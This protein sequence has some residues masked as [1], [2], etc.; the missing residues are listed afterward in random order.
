MPH[1]TLRRT[2]GRI[3]LSGPHGTRDLG[4]FFSLAGSRAQGVKAER[5][6]EFQRTVV[7]PV[8]EFLFGPKR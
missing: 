2:A 8:K 5:A 4:P 6:G 1:L 7:D 3:T